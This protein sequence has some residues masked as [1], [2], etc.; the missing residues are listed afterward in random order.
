MKKSLVLAMAMA[1]GVTAS[2]YAANPFS[3]V[4]AGHWAYDSI[5][6]LAAAGVIEGYGGSVNAKTA[7]ELFAQA[8]IDGGLVG[9]ASLK[10]EFGDIVNY[11]K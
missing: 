6:K 5:N 3:D 4:P 11:N 2:A 1:L 8:D 7:P 9:G 10:P